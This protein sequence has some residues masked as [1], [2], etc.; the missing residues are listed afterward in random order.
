MN[1]AIIPRRAFIEA[2][3]LINS[4][5]PARSSNPGLTM[6][7]IEAED[8]ALRLQGSSLDIDAE[9]TLTGDIDGSG[10]YALPAAVFASILKALPGDL[11]T[12]EPVESGAE[13]LVTSG[14]FSTRLQ[15][16]DAA[17]APTIAFPDEYET[18]VDARTLETALR[19]VRSAVARAEYQQIFRGVLLE[20]GPKSRAVATDGFRLIYYDLPGGL[21]EETRSIVMP[22]SSID[23][24]LRLLDGAED[25]S[26]TATE[27]VLHLRSDAA[28]LNV[29]LLEGRFPD[30]ERVI[31]AR[32]DMEFSVDAD[33]FS[34][35]VSRVAI[36]AD[37]SA[38]NRV[39][40]SVQDGALFLS[41]EGAYGRSEEK[42]D[43]IDVT[44]DATPNKKISLAYNANYLL[45]A[46]KGMAGTI[47][48]KLSGVTSPTII[49]CRDDAA[50]LSM[51]VPLRT[52]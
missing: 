25:V 49:T 39:D 47:D 30:Y 36:M 26:L 1:Q 31:P 40:I 9:T 38:N 27:S 41:S 8:G 7:V 22:G 34:E 28:K 10:R 45:D 23:E 5:V 33:E 46:I 52:E 14:K 42:L 12:L 13:L 3:G 19:R 35:T 20:L 16:S 11:V 24:V 51:V 32:F 48:V 29:K 2:F 37:K 15:L 18:E 4:V 50:H 43:D 21:Y 44:T 17:S 6:V